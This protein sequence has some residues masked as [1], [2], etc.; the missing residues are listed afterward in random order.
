[1][2]VRR[3]ALVLAVAAAAAC[4]AASPLDLRAFE[5]IPVLEGGRPMPLS[6]Y[7]RVAMLQTAGRGTWQGGPASGWL[8]RAMFESDATTNDAV[9][10]VSH[11]DTFDALGLSTDRPRRRVSYAELEPVLAKLHDLTSRAARLKPAARTPADRDLLHLGSAVS[12]YAAFS[13]GDHPGLLPREGGHGAWLSPSEAAAEPDDAARAVAAGWAA[14]RAAWLARDDAAFTAAAKDVRAA[15]L[16]GIDDPRAG[17]RLKGEETLGRTRPFSR[18]LQAYVVAAILGFWVALDARRRKAAT[19]A[20]ALVGLALLV[21]TAGLLLRAFIMGRPPVTNLYST[22]VFAGWCCAALGLGIERL[23]R[24]G[25]GLLAGGA[26]AAV[27]LAVAGRYELDGDTMQRVVAVLDSNFWL[28]V[29]VL[30]IMVGYAGCLMAGAAAHVQLVK[31]WR[32]GG[33]S[34]AAVARAVRGLLGL[35]LVFTFLGTMLGGVWADQSWGRFWGW[36]PKENGALLIV[37]WTA[38]ILHARGPRIVGDVGMAAGAVL[39]IVVVAV[40]WQ[41]VNLL[42]VGLHSYGFTSGA[43]FWLALLAGAELLFVA[44]LAGLIRAKDNAP[45][46]LSP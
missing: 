36:D 43:A 18:A 40:A 6:A 39:G 2:D 27:L 1:L 32:Q 31:H 28:T 12:L 42:G 24:D 23:R 33:E 41:G 14:L 17:A 45:P 37:L 21:H 5:S 25:L 46:R 3:A 16:R 11:P 44:A 9:F 4:R 8:A 34:A 15:V 35:G 13:R 38:A 22:F 20:V 30:T 29:H 19:A 7:A 26:T 10:L